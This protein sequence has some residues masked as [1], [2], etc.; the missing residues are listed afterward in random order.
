MRMLS[1]SLALTL[2]LVG[3]G[4]SVQRDETGRLLVGGPLSTFELQVGDCF[5]APPPGTL[6]HEV[7]AR[8]CAEPHAYEI[9][10]RASYP[11]APA[12]GF[13]GETALAAFAQTHCGEAVESYVGLPF[14]ETS[15]SVAY[16]YPTVGTWQEGDRAIL[17]ALHEGEEELEGSLQGS[18]R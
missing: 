7:E 10:A 11:A 17:C 2:L 4:Q 15:L 12:E 6:L 5:A 3:C 8:P 16:L 14:T 13:P 9:F 1:L 18:E